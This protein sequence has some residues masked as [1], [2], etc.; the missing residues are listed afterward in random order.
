MNTK[1]STNDFGLAST[2]LA[3]EYELVQLDRTNP[4]KVQFIFQNIEGLENVIVSFWNNSLC[5]SAQ[6]LLSA[7]RN[8]KSRLYS[9]T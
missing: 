4:G 2:L 7:Q 3:L 5:V 1:F 6:K 8:L 9:N